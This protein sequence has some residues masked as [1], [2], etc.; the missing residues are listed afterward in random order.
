MGKLTE[1]QRA[2]LQA[3]EAMSDDEIDLSDIPERE[4]DW[5][6]AKI[7]MHYQPDWQDI[8]LRLDQNLIDWFEEHSGNLGPQGHQPGSDGPHLAGEIPWT[9][10]VWESRRLEPNAHLFNSDRPWEATCPPTPARTDSKLES[11]T[12]SWSRAGSPGRT[13]TTSLR[14]FLASERTVQ[15]CAISLSRPSG[16][17]RRRELV[18]DDGPP[19]FVRLQLPEALGMVLWIQ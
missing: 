2:Q 7:G 13:R 14:R 16:G 17:R 11:A 8:T 15:I 5:F 10:A 4:V 3:L 1:E 12:C 6:T 18:G 19:A 9:Q